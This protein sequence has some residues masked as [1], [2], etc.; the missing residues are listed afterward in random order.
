MA[1]F[2]LYNSL[3]SLA[4]DSPLMD[5]DKAKIISTI[6]ILDVTESELLFGLIRVYHINHENKLE[7]IPYDGKKQKTGIKFDLKDFPNKLQRVILSFV[8]FHLQKLEDEKS[9]TSVYT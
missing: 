1:S 5:Q 8:N 3:I 2:P 4:D 9:R 6:K 7:S